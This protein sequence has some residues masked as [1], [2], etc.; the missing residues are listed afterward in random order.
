MDN[1]MKNNRLAKIEETILFLITIAGL[2]CMVV[3]WR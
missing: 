3:Y 2:L 1:S